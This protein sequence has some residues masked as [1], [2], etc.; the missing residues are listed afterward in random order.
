MARFGSTLVPALCAIVPGAAWIVSPAVARPQSPPS[1]PPSAI[2]LPIGT[3]IEVA[4]IRPLWSKTAA[5]GEQIYAQTTFPVAVQNR[6]AISPGT[7]VLGTLERLTRPGRHANRAELRVLFTEIIFANGYVVTLPALGVSVPGS[8]AGAQPA[9]Q[10]SAASLID[11]SVQVTARNDLLLDNGAQIE[12]TLGAPLQLDARQTAAAAPL[13]R[14]PAP[15]QFKSATMCRP[16]PAT[17]G[18]PGTPGTPDTVI[19][20]TP[21]TPDTVIPGGPGMPD[22]V[23]PGTPG[24]PDTVIPGTPGTPGTPGFSGVSCPAPPFVLSSKP[25]NAPA[26]PGQSSLPAAAP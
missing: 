15:G 12:V 7:F 21:G 16:V 17:P 20:G 13:S 22:T 1:G 18:T 2:T 9:P 3:K 14:P 25:V 11:V 6:I 5:P 24:T 19:P 23:I 26:N 8:S 4:L 10:D